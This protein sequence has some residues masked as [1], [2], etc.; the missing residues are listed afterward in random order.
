MNEHTDRIVNL[1][2]G[3]TETLWVCLGE[4]KS[5]TKCRANGFDQDFK[6]ILIHKQLLKNVMTEYDLLTP[7]PGLVR[8]YRNSKVMECSLSGMWD[9]CMYFVRA[10]SE[11]A[12]FNKVLPLVTRKVNL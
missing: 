10:D 11:I 12:I 2:Q 8:N 5:F 3:L 7:A 4:G 9:D 6:G 1:L